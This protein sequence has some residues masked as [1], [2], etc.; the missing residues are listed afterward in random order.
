MCSIEEAW[1][2]QN[3]EN[4]PV[5]SQADT[6]NAYM[7]LP[8]N[9][10]HRGNDLNLNEPNKPKSRELTRGINS[11]YSREPRV[12]KMVKNTN[13]VSMNISSQMPPLNNYGG[14]EP[15]PSFMTIY[16]N[17]AIHTQHHST[18]PHSTQPHSTQPTMSVPQPTTTG[19]HFTDID[20]A[21]QTS[22]LMNNFMG[23]GRNHLNNE[24]ENFDDNLINQNTSEED[25][26]I[27]RKFEIKKNRKNKKKS[28]FSN[29]NSKN[30]N[31]DYDNEY[32]EYE[33]NNENN[34]YENN[35]N[36]NEDNTNENNQ[37]IKQNDVH[38]EKILLSIINKLNQMDEN[39]HLYQKRN[40]YD[41]ILY[42]IVGMLLSFVIY[43]AMRK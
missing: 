3:F 34:E 33:N 24:Q 11:K 32:N 25:S 6:H 26:I 37:M 4:K 16:D 22:K 9:V 18:Q 42:I 39:L 36:D 31:N 17:K 29:I 1:A 13:D 40:M 23:V 21:F 12:P 30:N 43:S 38:I 19:D 8:D 41:I 27:N 14:L 10:F 15:L 35:E 2:G 28:K 7:S 5:V 20:N